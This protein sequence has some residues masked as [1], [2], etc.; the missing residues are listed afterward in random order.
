VD[1]RSGVDEVE[2]RKLLTL[3]VL[4][5]RPLNIVMKVIYFDRLDSRCLGTNGSKLETEILHCSV[6]ATGTWMCRGA[7]RPFG[8]L[9]PEIGAGSN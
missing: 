8:S 3:P 6:Q 5:I 4:E 9:A 1:P 7:C 2:K